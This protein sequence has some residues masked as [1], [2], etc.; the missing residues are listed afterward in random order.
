LIVKNTLMLPLWSF[1][2]A[3]AAPAPNRKPHLERPGLSKLSSEVDAEVDVVL[4]EPGIPDGRSHQRPER[5]P[6]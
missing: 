2:G 1:Q 5:L 6:E 4:G 3:R